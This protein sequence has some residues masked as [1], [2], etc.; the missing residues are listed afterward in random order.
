[1]ESLDKRSHMYKKHWTIIYFEHDMF[2]AVFGP[3][4]SINILENQ[5][6]AHNELINLALFTH[7]SLIN[8]S[9]QIPLWIVT[10]YSGLR[11]F[12]VTMDP[13]PRKS[14]SPR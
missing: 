13:E 10:V 12:A 7:E 1:M 14:S 11:S 6:G 3:T 8:L 4:C 5:K 2:T 9:F